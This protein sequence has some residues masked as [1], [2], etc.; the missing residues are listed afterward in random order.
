[1]IAEADVVRVDHQVSARDRTPASCCSMTARLGS[2]READYITVQQE[3]VV[4]QGNKE[5]GRWDMAGLPD[6]CVFLAV[7][8]S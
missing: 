3:E 6:F 2:Y 8:Y 7:V 4:E 1:M 5:D